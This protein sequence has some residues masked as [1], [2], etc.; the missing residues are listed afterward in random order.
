M[1]ILY[2]QKQTMARAS[3]PKRANALATAQEEKIARTV[4]LAFHGTLVCHRYNSEEARECVVSS[5]NNTLQDELFS[6]NLLQNLS[7]N[8]L[9]GQVVHTMINLEVDGACGMAAFVGVIGGPDR[10]ETYVSTFTPNTCHFNR[11][12][13]RV[14]DLKKFLENNTNGKIITT[15]TGSITR[16]IHGCHSEEEEFLGIKLICV[17]VFLFRISLKEPKHSPPF[18][19]F[20]SF[21]A[22]LMSKYVT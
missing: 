5:V 22:L 14:G 18:L 12:N 20:L 10:S 7:M 21:G 9:F 19:V 1:I 8:G 4:N 16:S 13:V 15:P 2:R 6:S 17:C 11:S 3:V